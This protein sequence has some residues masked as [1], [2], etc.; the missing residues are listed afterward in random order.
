MRAVRRRRLAAGVPRRRT[1][2]TAA[3]HAVEQRRPDA[4]KRAETCCRGAD[5]VSHKTF[6]IGTV[7][8]VAGDMLEVTFD[9]SGQTKKLMKGFAPI[10]KVG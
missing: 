9:K 4:A 5:K 6:G 1:Q 7:I 8:G 10:V 3:G 2:A